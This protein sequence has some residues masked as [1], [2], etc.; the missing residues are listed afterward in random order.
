M[1]R[2]YAVIAFIVFSVAASADQPDPLVKEARLA[3]KSFASELKG[4][5]QAEMEAGGPVNAIGVCNKRAP[6]IASK[7]NAGSKLKISRVSLRNRN[8]ANAPDDWQKKVLADFDARLMAGEDAGKIDYAETVETPGGQEFRYMKAIPTGEVCLNC[9]GA[10]LRDD[11]RAKLDELYPGD[12]ARGFKKGD[13][14]GAFYV[15]ITQ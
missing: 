5:L 13:I 14:R 12:K 1:N 11:V 2:I 10:N 9:H 15:T 3:I 8:P 4:E 7:V 6:E